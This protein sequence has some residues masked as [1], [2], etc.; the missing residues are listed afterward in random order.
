MAGDRVREEAERLVAAAIAAV[1][2]AA[3]GMGAAGRPT[4]GFATGSAECCVCPVCRLIASMRDPSGDIAERLA[5][6]A[7]DLANGVASMLRALGRGHGER[8]DDRDLEGEPGQQGDEFWESM[9]QR[10]TEQARAWSGTP[11]SGRGRPTDVDDDESDVES[12]PWRVATTAAS[13]PAPP[14]KPMAKKALAKKVMAKKSVAPRVIIPG[15]AEPAAP[16]SSPSPSA[17][18]VTKAT[19]KKVAPKKVAPKK[20]TTAA[21]GRS[22]PAQAASKTAT[23][24]KSAPKKTAV[25]KAAPPAEESE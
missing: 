7:G 12:D 14:S 6:G 22:V 13:T 11:W 4:S 20:A 1:S 18:P 9:R 19:A 8:N 23:P 24:E 17:A 15:A 25:K 16:P 2:L 3:R 5:T 21:P 10:A